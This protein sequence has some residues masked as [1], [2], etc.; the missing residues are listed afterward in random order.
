[1]PEYRHIVSFTSPPFAQTEFELNPIDTVGYP[2]DNLFPSI[3]HIF[4]FYGF[5][6]G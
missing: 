2:M 4:R 3:W 1:M 5:K 6:P